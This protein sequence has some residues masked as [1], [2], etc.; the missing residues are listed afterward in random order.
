MIDAMLI[1]IVPASDAP[2]ALGERYAAQAGWDA[3]ADSAN[4]VYLALGPKRIQVWREGE[5]LAGRT[6]MRNGEWVV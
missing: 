4:Y 6:V 3:R 1:E 5:D 2:A